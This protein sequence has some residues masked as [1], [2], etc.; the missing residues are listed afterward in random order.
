MMMMMSSKLHCHHDTKIYLVT[1]RNAIEDFINL[2][3]YFFVY[4]DWYFLDI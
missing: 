2:C 4:I 3:Y 1:S